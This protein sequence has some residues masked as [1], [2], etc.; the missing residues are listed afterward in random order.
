MNDYTSIRHKVDG[1]T[2]DPDHPGEYSIIPH[3]DARPTDIVNLRGIDV[4]EISQ[5]IC[6]DPL[7]VSL[8]VSLKVYQRSVGVNTN[9]TLIPAPQ[10]TGFRTQPQS[11]SVGS[12]A[13][14][15]HS[16]PSVDQL[17]RNYL[18]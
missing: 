12:S 13:E 11:D 3:S 10:D 5:M 6:N 16:N 17:I 8:N 7:N 14:S 9:S 1:S 18:D 15:F 2:V 4:E